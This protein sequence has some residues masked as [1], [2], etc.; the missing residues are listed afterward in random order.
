M[1]KTGSFIILVVLA[2]FLM[3]ACGDGP[4]SQTRDEGDSV[5]VE[6]ETEDGTQ[7]EVDIPTSTG[8]PEDF[9]LP[10]YPDWTVLTAGKAEI[11]DTRLRWNG[12]FEFEG[13]VTALAEE[14]LG[15]V[16]DLGY[17]ANLMQ[18]GD[19]HYGITLT[20][21]Y[22]GRPVDGRVSIGVAGEKNIINISFG[23]PI[24]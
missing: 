7:V 23:D 12:S 1:R 6:L 13:S 16:Q 4:A 11:D 9:P 24:D 3:A 22:E 15:V 19:N 10:V 17:D 5:R 14:Y 20:G 2:M 8:V 18:V 21:T